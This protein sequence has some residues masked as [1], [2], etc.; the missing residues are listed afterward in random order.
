MNGLYPMTTA[1]LIRVIRGL[2]IVVI[3]A[4]LLAL[5]SL[6]MAAC[7]VAGRIDIGTPNPPTS[8]CP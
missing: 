1:Q 3:V 6:Y 5:F 4:L 8:N 2:W 7:S